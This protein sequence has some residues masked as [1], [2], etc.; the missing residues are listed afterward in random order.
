MSPPDAANDVVIIVVVVVSAVER[1]I[2][3]CER[4]GWRNNRRAGQTDAAK[5]LKAAAYARAPERQCQNA[6]TLL[7]PAIQL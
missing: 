2:V 7:L 1:A 4:R 6:G 5:P 3:A